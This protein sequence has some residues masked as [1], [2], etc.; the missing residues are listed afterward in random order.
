MTEDHDV[1]VNMSM[2][3]SYADL[4]R[5]CSKIAQ[6]KN[7][8]KIPLYA[9]FPCQFWPSSRSASVMLKYTGKFKVKNL[10]RKNN[11]DLH[12]VRAVLKFLRWRAM[13][14]RDSVTFFSANAKCKVN[15]GKPGYPLAAIAQGKKVKFGENELFQVAD[16]DFS[17][18]SIIP[19]GVLEYIKFWRMRKNLLIIKMMMVWKLVYCV[20]REMV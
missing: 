1:V 12:Y 20:I 15:V 9:G 13:Q 14:Y 17:K 3:A 5:K 7:I 11:P 16:H 18:L 2:S 6:N 19:D 8:T 4:Y 10:L